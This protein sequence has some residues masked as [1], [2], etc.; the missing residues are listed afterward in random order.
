M[1]TGYRLRVVYDRLPQ[2]LNRL[3]DA[4]GDAVEQGAE[5]AKDNIQAI[6][7]VAT[8]RHKNG[9]T[10]RRT[11][12]LTAQ[13]ES[14]PDLE[15]PVYLEYGTSRMAARPHF[16]PGG[17]GSKSAIRDLIERAMMAIAR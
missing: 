14:D 13:V 1:T 9:I 17:D 2:I 10:V 16:T 15:Y 5:T 8:G 11:S 6:T 7:P 4:V 3:D 12:Q